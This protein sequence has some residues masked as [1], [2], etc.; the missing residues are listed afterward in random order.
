MEWG[1]A[2]RLTQ[3]L[4]GDPGSQLAAAAEGWDYPFPREVAV[5]ADLYD[6]Q[7]AKTGAKNR[8]PYPRPFKVGADIKVEKIGNMG[9][10][11]RAE[12]VEILRA[13]G[14]NLPV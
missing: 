3:I 13:L 10:R 5:T 1:E 7:H 11:S 14:H 6:L 12:V 8:K 9:G 4:R 2:L